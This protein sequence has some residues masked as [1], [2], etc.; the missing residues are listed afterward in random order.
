MR[1]D[2]LPW[3]SVSS[4]AA[5]WESADITAG[6]VIYRALI[7]LTT[8]DYRRYPAGYCCIYDRRQFKSSNERYWLQLDPIAAQCLVIN[9]LGEN[10]HDRSSTP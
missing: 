5:R 2:D 6:V 4:D 10:Y 3:V 8:S 1:L 9:L 7:D